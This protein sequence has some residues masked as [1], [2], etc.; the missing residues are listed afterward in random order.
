MTYY[1]DYFTQT[2]VKEEDREPGAP[3]ER[4][5]MIEA[6]Q[7][8]EDDTCTM[9]Y[10]IRGGEGKT[11]SFSYEDG[12]DSFDFNTELLGCLK[13]Q[14]L[15]TKDIVWPARSWIVPQKRLEQL[16]KECGVE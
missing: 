1:W 12:I 10:R 2:L 5:T 6:R 16:K 9:T 4:Y 3:A 14:G 13:S 15:T 7:D 8:K 11:V